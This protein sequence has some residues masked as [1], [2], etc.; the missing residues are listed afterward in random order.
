[1]PTQIGKPQPGGEENADGGGSPILRTVLALEPVLVL[2]PRAEREIIVMRNPASWLPTPKS[3]Y[4]SGQRS[5]GKRA[6]KG[7]QRPVL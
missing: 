2:A 4:Q 5:P 7:P 6:D 3:I 1:M